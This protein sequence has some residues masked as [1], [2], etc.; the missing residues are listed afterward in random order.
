MPRLK[1]ERI[2]QGFSQAEEGSCASMAADEALRKFI[3][4]L[5]R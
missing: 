4:S 5:S 2:L 3:N 1:A